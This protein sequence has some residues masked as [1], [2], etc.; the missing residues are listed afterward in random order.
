M[1]GKV[2]QRPRYLEIKDD[3]EDSKAVIEKIMGQSLM[4]MM[5]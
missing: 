2:S 1:E 5:L 3:V 4:A